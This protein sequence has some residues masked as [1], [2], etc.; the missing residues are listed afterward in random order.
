MTRER[1][2]V[3]KLDTETVKEALW[4]CSR[5]ICSSECPLHGKGLVCKGVTKLM[6]S[7][8][9]IIEGEKERK[10]KALIDFADSIKRSRPFSPFIRRST[11]DR[12]LEKIKRR[13]I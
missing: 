8:L 2:A 7:A 5:G 4:Y 6:E 1:K 3:Q 12:E 9:A 11:I 13:D 10:E